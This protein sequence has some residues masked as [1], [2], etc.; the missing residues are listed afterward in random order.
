MICNRNITQTWFGFEIYQCSNIFTAAST[1]HFFD[2]SIKVQHNQLFEEVRNT[3]SCIKTIHEKEKEEVIISEEDRK[4]STFSSKSSLLEKMVNNFSTKEVELSQENL[5]RISN[6]EPV[7][8]QV[9]GNLESIS[10]IKGVE[11]KLNLKQRVNLA[12]DQNYCGSTGSSDFSTNVK[13]KFLKQVGTPFTFVE[14]FGKEI[15]D[16][17]GPVGKE[18][19]DTNTYVQRQRLHLLETFC[20]KKVKRCISYDSWWLTNSFD[21]IDLLY[22]FKHKK[23]FSRTS[24]NCLQKSRSCEMFHGLFHT[25]LTMQSKNE[26]SL[27]SENKSFVSGEEFMPRPLWISGKTSD[28]FRFLIQWLVV[29][30][31]DIPLV[32]LELHFSSY[33]NNTK[34]D[35]ANKN[36]I[37][38]ICIEADKK[39]WTTGDLM[40]IISREYF[41]NTNESVEDCARRALYFHA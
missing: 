32:I 21:D 40:A 17:A 22:N 12:L 8:N 31:L 30:L 3:L 26:S 15:G 20:H 35:E 39:G 33:S 13:S 29:S 6:D 9:G 34:A 4:S 28:T 23:L 11:E 5:V 14:N 16:A 10:C 25:P 19:E 41:Q 2:I 37:A 24:Q 38:K 27:K 7:N 36:A 18:H 1:N